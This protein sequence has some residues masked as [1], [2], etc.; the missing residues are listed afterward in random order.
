MTEFSL[1]DLDLRLN[2]VE[3][4]LLARAL[5]LAHENRC[6]APPEKRKTTDGFKANHYSGDFR[7]QTHVL[8]SAAQD[9]FKANGRD[10]LYEA[11][12]KN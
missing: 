8:L 6:L 2:A 9:F 4:Q 11:E 1:C 3:Q 10:W 5:K 7:L 12:K